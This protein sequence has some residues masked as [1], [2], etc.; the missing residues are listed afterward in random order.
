MLNDPPTWDTPLFTRE[1]GNVS[2]TALLPGANCTPAT[3]H[4]LPDLMVIGDD[5]DD[6]LR[7]AFKAIERRRRPYQVTGVVYVRLQVR[8][9]RRA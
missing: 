3:C 7:R 6:A 1:S 9:T 5:P 4:E 8:P 2:V